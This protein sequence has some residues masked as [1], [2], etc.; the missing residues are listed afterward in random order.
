MREVIGPERDAYVRVWTTFERKGNTFNGVKDFGLKNGSNK[1]HNL[2]LT[3]LFV[4]K[5]VDSG[6]M[7]SGWTRPS[8]YH[9]ARRR[10]A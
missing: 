7:T 6:W 1:V 3:V 9:I 8:W 10:K 4:P 5:S 2:A